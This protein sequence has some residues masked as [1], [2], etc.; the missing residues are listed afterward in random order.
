MVLWC[1]IEKV[2]FKFGFEKRGIFK[3]ISF[4]HKAFHGDFWKRLLHFHQE[5]SSFISNLT[6]HRTNMCL[7]GKSNSC[8]E[9]DDECIGIVINGKTRSVP[10]NSVNLYQI[11]HKGAV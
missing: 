3:K 8:F 11:T 4:L 6:N 9:S 5:S 1:L 7:P 2:V 10:S